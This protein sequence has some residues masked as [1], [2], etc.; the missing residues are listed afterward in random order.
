[1]RYRYYTAD[2]FTDRPFG[3]N[4]LAVFPDGRGLSTRQMQAIAA[5]FNYSETT[6]VF[7]PQDARHT[8]RVRIFT[9]GAEMPFAGHP[10]VGTAHVL[11]AIGEVALEGEVTRIVLEEGVGPVPVAIRAS[12]GKPVFAQLSA[13]QMPEYGPPAPA[14]GIIASALSLDVADVLGGADYPQAISCGVRFLFV[15]LRNR[16]AVRRARLNRDVWEKHI[17]SYWASQIYLF[18]Y[19]AELPGSQLRARMFAPALGIVEDPATGSGA[20]ALAGYLG[21]RDATRDGLLHWRVEQGFEMGRP[22]I[23]EVEADKVNGAITGIR[24]GGATVMMCAGTL[25]VAS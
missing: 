12:E 10:T 6:F 16:D 7:P 13:A 19:D 25:E 21:T 22:S 20:T 2:V 14:A 5:E 1:M 4:Q 23:L 18:S 15:P 24:V 3:G 9:P 11:A 8:R 17:A